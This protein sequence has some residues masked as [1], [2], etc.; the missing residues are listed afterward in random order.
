[1]Y[2]YYEKS[3]YIDKNTGEAKYV[4]NFYVIHP[5]LKV[6]LKL[7]PNDFTTREI[8]YQLVEDG[9]INNIMEVINNWLLNSSI[10]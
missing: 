2:L 5:T 9:Q 4:Y 3:Q 8:L 1:M 6:K 10:L 7:N